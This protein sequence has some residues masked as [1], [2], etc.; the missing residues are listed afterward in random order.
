[1]FQ[2][3]CEERGEKPLKENQPQSIAFGHGHRQIIYPDTQPPGCALF[4]SLSSSTLGSLQLVLTSPSSSMTEIRYISLRSLLP[5]TDYYMTYEGSTTYPGCWETTVWII[6]NKPIYITKQ[7]LY[8]LR[9]L[10]QGL[11]ETPK[12]PL[13][14][15]ARPIQELFHRTVRTNI[16]FRKEEVERERRLAREQGSLEADNT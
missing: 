13:G 12:A 9:Q 2:R 7:E 5:D 1:M 14:N 4:G 6:L 10:K 3:S 15:N 8:A 11:E 16:D